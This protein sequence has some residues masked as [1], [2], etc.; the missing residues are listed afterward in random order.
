MSLDNESCMIR[1]FII[2]LNRVE[3]KYYPFIISLVKCN[4]SCNYVNDL[5]MRI[6]KC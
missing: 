1:P 5:S 3:L 6:H 4:G 2:D